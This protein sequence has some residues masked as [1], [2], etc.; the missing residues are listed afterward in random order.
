MVDT[1]MRERARVPLWRRPSV[2][3]GGGLVLAALVVF[4]LVWFQPQALLF[5]RVVDE[6]FP[7]AGETMADEP[8]DDATEDDAAE[9]DD[10]VEDD[11]ADA[12]AMAEGRGKAQ[13]DS[14]RAARRD[15]YAK[16]LDAPRRGVGHRLVSASALR[17]DDMV[18]VETSEM[19]PGDGGVVEGVASVTTLPL[20]QFLA[21]QANTSPSP[22]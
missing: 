2:L 4:V 6:G 5:D 3:I 13:A 16:K 12:E 14:L 17:K 18:L 1:R 19:F 10:P 7:T 15:V 8:V 20:L 21:P 9:D 11:G 22:A